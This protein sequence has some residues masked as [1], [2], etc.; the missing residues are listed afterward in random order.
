MTQTQKTAYHLLV[1]MLVMLLLYALAALL[2]AVKF[3]SPD[4]AL[5]G[6]LPYNQVGALANVLLQLAVLTGLLGGGVYA[7]LTVRADARLPHERLVRVG[8]GL[9]TALLALA[10]IAGLLGVLEGRH[11]LELPPLLDALQIAAAGVIGLAVM[12]SKPR[13]PAVQVWLVGLGISLL[14]GL[15]GLIVPGDFIQAR[16]LQTLV[17]GMTLYV[18]Y[19]LMAVALGF[20]LMQRFSNVTPTWAD[21]GIYSV[22]GLVTAA[23]ALLV[24]PPL[25]ALEAAEW[26]GTLGTISAVV[27]PVCYLIFAAHGYRALSDRNPT[28]TLA[29]HWFAL[30]LLLFLLGPGLL[31]ALQAVPDI[32]RYTLG[33]R[34]SDLQTTLTVFAPV[35][36]A[37]GVAN[38]VAAELRGHNRRVTGFIPFWLAAFGMVIAALAAGAAGVAQ[39]YLERLLSVGYLDTQTLLVPLYTL[40]LGGL[41]LAALGLVIYALT[42]WRRR[43]VA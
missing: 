42:F 19:P 4:D 33:T 9:W 24:L 39:T 20:W 7:A 30:A 18:A 13:L 40:W 21:T 31:G 25:Y 5:A 26:V 2:G 34:L 3:L 29:A 23:G 8:A 27:I 28:Q 10:V 41:A 36:L 15:A 1:Q 11:L 22:A 17:A 6:S 43:P 38:Q 16:A 12:T 37:L 14:A 35:A 32:S